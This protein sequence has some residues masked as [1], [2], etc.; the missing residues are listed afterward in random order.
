MS[1][2]GFSVEE[3]AVALDLRPGQIKMHYPRELEAASVKA[4]M[5]VAKAFFD[6]AKSGTNWQA[7][8][9]WLKNRAGWK[10]GGTDINIGSG[11]SITINL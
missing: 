5:Q 10:D 2:L 4:N 7:S 8:L 11:L 3:I 9:S 6:V 1:A